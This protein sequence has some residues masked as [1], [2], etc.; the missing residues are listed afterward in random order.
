MRLVTYALTGGLVLA[1]CGPKPAAKAPG[2]AE[3]ER[4]SAEPSTLD[5]RA[6]VLEVQG[7]ACV[8][9]KG[10]EGRATVHDGRCL[11]WHRPWGGGT[12]PPPDPRP[13]YDGTWLC[14]PTVAPKDRTA[15]GVDARGCPRAE[16]STGDAC[17]DR[18][19][20]L[21]N[22]ECRW[23]AGDGA[24]LVHFRCVLGRWKPVS[25]A[26]IDEREMNQP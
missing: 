1:S 24:S 20:F 14:R 13:V 18:A 25:Q 12:P 21:R 22:D 23:L 15:A 4:V 26:E 9:E 11:C 10:Q 16:P 19:Q 5:D 6:S 3:P 17:D 8:G 7:T 2:D